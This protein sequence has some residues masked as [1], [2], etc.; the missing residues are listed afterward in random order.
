MKAREFVA[1]AYC[2]HKNKVLL[3][4]HRKLNLW[5]PPGGHLD[6]DELPCDCAVREFKEETGLDIELIGKAGPLGNVKKLIHPQLVQLDPID[7]KHEHINLLYLA[8][9]KNPNQ[10]IVFNEQETKNIK[11]FSEEELD[12]VAEEVRIPAKKAIEEL[13]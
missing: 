3:I 10:S 7:E 5:I 13:K 9:L 8:K 2:I 6:K 4:Y 11:W 12:R 1:G